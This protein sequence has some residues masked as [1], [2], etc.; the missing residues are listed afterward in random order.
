MTPDDVA[1]YY[2]RNTARFLRLGG[3]GQAAAIHRAVWAPGITSSEEAFLFLNHWVALALLPALKTP[4]LP[5]RLLDL[6]CGVGGTATWLAHELKVT[7]VGLT[8]SS[9]QARLAGERARRLEL[10]ERCQFL[11]ADFLAAPL[12]VGFQGIYAIESFVHARDPVR[13]FDEVSRLLPHGGRLA[14]CDDFLCE[15]AEVLPEAQPWLNRFREGW[16]IKNL[17]TSEETIRLAS[18]A[19]LRLCADK[20]LSA[21]VCSVHPLALRIQA[22]V[23]CLPLRSA[24]WQN[25]SGGAALQVCIKS[26]WT[27]YRAL[28]WEIG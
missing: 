20:D 13:F 17:L 8:N 27:S 22:A 28:A 1:H 21:Y 18:Q 6:G 23:T 24:Y 14:I 15:G 19:G 3:S 9:V 4:G 7:V 10:K 2:D 12:A 16:H 11:A 25:L 5:A 26:G